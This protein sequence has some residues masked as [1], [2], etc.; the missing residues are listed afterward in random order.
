[1]SSTHE[2]IGGDFGQQG[3]KSRGILAK[4]GEE[5]KRKTVWMRE[6]RENQLKKGVARSEKTEMEKA[7][8]KIKGG[9]FPPF[10]VMIFFVTVYLN[11]SRCHQ[12]QQ[13]Y[14]V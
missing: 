8:K 7:I 11:H 14:V 3:G 1:M 4:E 6:E 5:R 2:K 10:L 13:E 9:K 12:T